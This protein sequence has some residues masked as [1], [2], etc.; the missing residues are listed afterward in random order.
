MA[1]KKC[2]QEEIY[3]NEYLIFPI[4]KFSVS[5]LYFQLLIKTP[6]N[7]RFK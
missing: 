5:F 6:E 3:L 7:V 2:Y 4:I 1:I